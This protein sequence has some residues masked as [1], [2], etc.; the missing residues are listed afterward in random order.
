MAGIDIRHPHSLPLD[1][2]RL[3]VEQ[4]AQKLSERFEVACDWQD[5]TLHFSRSGVEGRIALEPNQV[6]VTASLGFLL[7]AMKGPIEAE[8]RRVLAERFGDSASA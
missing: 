7:S 4:V 5:D 8:I 3:S 1:Q 6:H 2:A